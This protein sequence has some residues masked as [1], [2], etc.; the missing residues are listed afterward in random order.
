MSGPLPHIL[1]RPGASPTSDYFRHVDATRLSKAVTWWCGKGHSKLSRAERETKLVAAFK[2]QAAV[3]EVM[4]NL[5]PPERAV[6]GAYRRFGGAVNGT[7]LRLDLL[8]RGVLEI[9]EDTRWMSRITRWKR[10]VVKELAERLVLLPPKL[11]G[12][13]SHRGYAQETERP[14]PLYALHPA[15]AKQVPP[16]GPAPFDLP[17]LKGAP[18]TTGRRS[19]G[20]VALDLARVFSYVADRNGVRLAKSGAV[21]GPALK[22]LAKAVPVGADAHYPLPAPQALYL[23][24]LRHAGALR[25]EPGDLLPDGDLAA[26]WFAEPTLEQARLWARGWLAATSWQDGAGEIPAHQRSYR[27]PE[28]ALR[29][30]REVLAWCLSGLAQAGERWFGLTAFL[31]KLQAALGRTDYNAP[32]A[33]AEGWAPNF[34]EAQYEDKRGEGRERALWFEREGTWYANALMVTLVQLALVERGRTGKDQHC[35]RLT[36][37]G[38]A[39]FGAPEVAPPEERADE[40]FL[41]VQP[42]FDVLAYLDRAR[43]A[44]AAFLGRLTETGGQ[45]LSAVQTFRLTQSSV[46]RAME[47]GLSPDEVRNFLSRHSQNELPANLARSLS[48]WA[49]RRDALV[50]R[51]GAT[52]LAFPDRAQRDAYLVGHPGSACGE[53]FVLAEGV[54]RGTY[55]PGALV[56][57]HLDRLRQTWSLDERGCLHVSGLYD[58]VQ[59]ARLRRIADETAEG[60]RLTGESVRQAG[61]EGLKPAALK[62]W[63]EDHLTE[64]IPP[65][66]D[67]ALDAW[68]GMNRSVAMGEVVLLE[69]PDPALFAAIANSPRLSPLLAG[70]VGSGWLVVRREA[71]KDLKAALA[72]LGF[73]VGSEITPLTALP[74]DEDE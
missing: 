27:E 60:W 74:E 22:A 55:P 59:A 14:F 34:P 71:R 15:L 41:V 66:F 20:E 46:Y 26:A 1:S 38:R 30:A 48:D 3:A 33:D 67:H 7:V 49:G 12:E 68:L 47:G 16:A 36:E 54:P 2:D 42:N 29:T 53:H 18:E 37:W 10:D 40:R 24:V 65:L 43:P 57:D 28:S 35:F 61:R 9:V 72:E 23:E 63:L 56:G 13:S 39:A 51:R 50:V 58:L 17:L 73:L 31:S 70:T 69:V 32:R 19:P 62:S 25:D 6:L 52:V 64:P 21:A 8:A 44:E 11:G 4:R 45:S 5:G